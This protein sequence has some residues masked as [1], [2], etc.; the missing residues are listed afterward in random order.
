VS[1]TGHILIIDDE[2]SLR[3]TLGRILQRAGHEVTT[4]ESG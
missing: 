1:L 3:Q 4:A 2:T